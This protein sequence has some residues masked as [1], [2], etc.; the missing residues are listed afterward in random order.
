MISRFDCR[1]VEVESP[2]RSDE[3]NYLTAL[4]PDNSFSIDTHPSFGSI[5]LA[6]KQHLRPL[7]TLQA[8]TVWLIA[9]RLADCRSSICGLSEWQPCH[10]LIALEEIHETNEQKK[11]DMETQMAARLSLFI[12]GSWLASP[13]V[14]LASPWVE[15]A[16]PWSSWASP[17][18]DD[19]QEEPLIPQGPVVATVRLATYRRVHLVAEV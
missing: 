12:H 8:P 1:L 2:P 14:E 18:Q 3:A 19:S 7:W 10:V 16:S 4:P 9:L 17:S 15:L 6:D 13:W 11:R 5:L